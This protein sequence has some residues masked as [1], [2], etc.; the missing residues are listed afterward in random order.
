M[1]TFA[2]LTV[3]TLADRSLGAHSGNRE[4]VPRRLGLSVEWIHDDFGQVCE[5]V[6]HHDDAPFWRD[7]VQR[8]WGDAFNKDDKLRG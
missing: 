4:Y 1:V 2:K 8:G 5:S 7:C 3:D 6:Q